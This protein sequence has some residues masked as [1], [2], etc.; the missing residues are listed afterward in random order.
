MGAGC[1][2]TLVGS[3]VD[4]DNF[5]WVCSSGCGS[6]SVILSQK[7]YTCM[8]ASSSQDWELGEYTFTYVFSSAGKFTI[9]LD[10]FL[11]K[12]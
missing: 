1:T 3:Y 9:R 12:T 2:S 7:G 4:N 5:P 11:S 10:N 6:S 8:A